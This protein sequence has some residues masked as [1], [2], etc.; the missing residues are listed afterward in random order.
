[1]IL[2]ILL[3][4]ISSI[5]ILPFIYMISIALASD[6]TSTKMTFTLFP[7]EWHFSNFL[8]V[9]SDPRLF[10]W[11]KNSALITAAAIAGQIFSSS[12]VAYGFARLRAP[13]KNFLFMVLHS[14]MITHTLIVLIYG[15]EVYL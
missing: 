7:K 5:L 1:M 9:Y 6:A 11:M 4:T 12:L 13:G 14:K 15:K 3:I 8:R 10:T 2:Y